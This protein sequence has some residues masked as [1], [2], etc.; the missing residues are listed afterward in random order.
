[1][2]AALYTTVEKGALDLIKNY[3]GPIQNLRE[4]AEKQGCTIVAEYVDEYSQDPQN[5]PARQ[6]LIDDSSA[7]GFQ[8][9][10]IPNNSRFC[11]DRITF[12]RYQNILAKK[13]VRIISLSP[14]DGILQDMMDD[15]TAEMSFSA[16]KE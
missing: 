11:R 14:G 1:M 13:G 15:V 7:G 8:A 5:R 4:A 16:T 2:N 3:P 9:V 12:S 10:V 6:K